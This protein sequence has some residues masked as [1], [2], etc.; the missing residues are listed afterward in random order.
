LTCA[1]MNAWTVDVA[2]TSRS[3]HV[4]L[5]G[6]GVL[7]RPCAGIALIMSVPPIPACRDRRE[8]AVRR[9]PVDRLGVP[10]GSSSGL[11]AGPTCM[12]A[13]IGQGCVPPRQAYYDRAPGEQI[14]PVSRERDTSPDGVCESADYA[15]ATS[16]TPAVSS[17][18]LTCGAGPCRPAPSHRSPT[19]C[20]AA[21]A[22]PG[23]PRANHVVA[24]AARVHARAVGPCGQS[25]EDAWAHPGG[26]TPSHGARNRRSPSSRA[27]RSTQK[28]LAAETER[29]VTG[30]GAAT[31]S[32]SGPGWGRRPSAVPSAPA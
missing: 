26:A 9:A 23:R 22:T 14:V 15:W 31:M 27:A 19:T 16:S 8:G 28:R 29:V 12:V 4:L 11:R 2:A 3:S 30:G 32:T 17:R 18:S 10:Q 25:L 20:R 24:A 13:G 6:D 1:W 21:G 7:E 5:R